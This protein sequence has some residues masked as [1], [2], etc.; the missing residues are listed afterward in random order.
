MDRTCFY[1]VK[2]RDSED[3]EFED[4][5]YLRTPEAVEAYLQKLVA[6]DPDW[7]QWPENEIDLPLAIQVVRAELSD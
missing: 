3:G 5:A 2:Q 4:A 1:I 6:L 7:R